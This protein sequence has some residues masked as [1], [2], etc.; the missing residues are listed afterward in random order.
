MIGLIQHILSCLAHSRGGTEAV[1][2][3]R[4]G[5]GVAPDRVYR[6]R[7]SYSDE[8]FSRLLHSTLAHF[9]WDEDTFAK[10]FAEV[11][12]ADALERWPEWFRTAPDARAFLERQVAI[13]NTF[14]SG[15]ADPAVRDAVN[16]KFRIERRADRHVTHYRS[17]N[18]VCCLYKALARGVLSHWGEEARLEEPRCMHRGDP[19]CEIHVVWE[20]P[21]QEA[22]GGP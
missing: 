8:E 3:I 1:N 21:H 17:P 22:H 5:A 14:A 6:I 11:F 16:D 18:R 2:A 10:A 20:T 15:Q 12:L 19:A 13:H 4:A 9:A 7:E